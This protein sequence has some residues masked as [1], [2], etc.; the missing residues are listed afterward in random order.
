MMTTKPVLRKILLLLTVVSALAGPGPA[1][2]QQQV[3]AHAPGSIC[4]TQNFWCWAQP[5][6]IPGTPCGCPSPFGFVPGTLG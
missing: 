6:G 1:W 2:S 4:F 5:P 3:P